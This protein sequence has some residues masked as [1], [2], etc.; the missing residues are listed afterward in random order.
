MELSSYSLDALTRRRPLVVASSSSQSRTTTATKSQQQQQRRRSDDDGDDTTNTA[1]AAASS[2]PKLQRTL[3]LS[4]VIFYGVGCSV[5]AG[6]YSLVGIGAGI[7]GPSIALSFLVCGVACCFTSLAYAE[8]A[9]R[10]PLAGSAYTFVYVSFGELAGWLVGWNLTLGYA[11]SAAV[12]ARS[13]AEYLVEFVYGFVEGED[14][15]GDNNGGNEDVAT[16]AAAVLRTPSYWTKLPLHMLWGG[17]DGDDPYTCCPLSVLIIGICTVILITGVKESTKFNTAMTILNLSILGFVLVAGASSVLLGN[18][19]GDSASVNLLRP[20]FPHG[21]TGMARGAGLVFFSYLGF[22]MVACLSEECDNPGR[23]M[24]IGIIG[25]LMASMTIYVSVSLVVVAMT[26]IALLGQDTPITNALLANAC[27]TPQQQLADDARSSCLSYSR[28]EPVV[29]YVLYVGSRFISFGAIFGLTT[30]TFACLMGQ[31]RIN[32]A[33]AQDGLLFEMFCKVH[34]KTGVPTVGTIITGTLTALAACFIDLEVLANAISLGTLQVFSFVS[35]GVII[36]RLQGPNWIRHQDD[37]DDDEIIVV[38]NDE[39]SSV[40]VVH[41]QNASETSRLLS[42]AHEQPSPVARDPQALETAR[43]LGLIKST[44]IRIRRLTRIQLEQVLGQDDETTRPVWLVL[45]F[46]VSSVVLSLS[47]ANDWSASL[48]ITC[49]GVAAVSCILLFLQPQSAPPTETFA[50]PFVPA[51]PLL[52]ISCNAY[53]MGSLP[54]STWWA[55]LGWLFVGL[56][57]Y[58][59]YGIH[60]SKLK[61]RNKVGGP[62]TV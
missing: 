29:N 17:D 18:A 20:F 28:C 11:V 56:L 2:R 40:E 42:T 62:G 4:D 19:A 27:C 51:V 41:Q 24:P 37:E 58:L 59:L 6:I 52:S 32:Y 14:G 47:A 5:G 43:S 48:L 61:K 57:F 39:D 53:M 31:P 8:F 16:I 26:P 1:S 46:A 50:C 25:S 35:A 10:V 55:I 38:N 22:D 54:L 9:A 45:A 36:L 21:I 13:W 33:A 30:A 23:N 34:P 7:A 44:S 60:H 15:G 12:V 49:A 3:S